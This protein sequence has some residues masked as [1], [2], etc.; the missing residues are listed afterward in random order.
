MKASNHAQAPEIYKANPYVK[1]FWRGISVLAWK[2]SLGVEFKVPPLDGAWK[3]FWE[4]WAA[5]GQADGRTGGR[6]DFKR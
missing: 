5:G 4:G 3:M 6:A 1:W 2:S